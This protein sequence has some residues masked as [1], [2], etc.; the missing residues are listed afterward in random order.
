MVNKSKIIEE[1]ALNGDH[2]ETEGNHELNK[3]KRALYWVFCQ[4]FDPW[5]NP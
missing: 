4:I 1:R 2:F 5:F 3:D